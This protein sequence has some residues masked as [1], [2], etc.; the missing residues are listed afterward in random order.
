V[1]YHKVLVHRKNPSIVY[2]WTEQLAARSDMLR[3]GYLDPST[4]EIH[5]ELPKAKPKPKKPP[6]QDHEKL[7][8]PSL[9]S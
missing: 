6:E 4:K 2:G 7:V 3:V 1:D 8:L 9:D 5:D